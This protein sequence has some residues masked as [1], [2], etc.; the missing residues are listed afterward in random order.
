MMIPS[1][2][3]QS[4]HH[5]PPSIIYHCDSIALQIIPFEKMALIKNKVGGHC[6]EYDVNKLQWQTQLHKEVILG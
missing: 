6:I 3:W 2:S 5:P 4:E 1:Q